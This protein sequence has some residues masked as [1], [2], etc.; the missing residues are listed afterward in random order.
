MTYP[1]S[2]KRAICHQSVSDSHHDLNYGLKYDPEDV[3]KARIRTVGVQEYQFLL[4]TGPDK[5]R[6]WRVYDCG[7]HHRAPTL[8]SELTAISMKEAPGTNDV[9]TPPPNQTLFYLHLSL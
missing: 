1:V 7:G 4:E 9:I 6:E 2:L 3:L 8:I 5:G